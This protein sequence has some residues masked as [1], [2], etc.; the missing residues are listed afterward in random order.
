MTT[1]TARL[2][3]PAFKTSRLLD[4]VG[5][6]ELTAQI[7]HDAT[8][9]PLVVLKEGFDNALDACE[10]AGIAPVIL[11]E[12]STRAGEAMISVT[13]NGPGL[14]PET[15]DDI[16]DFSTR[17]SSREAYCS[18]TRGAQGNALKT[19]VAMPYALGDE[20]AE[21][22]IESRNTWHR[23]TFTADAVHQIPRIS[24][25]TEPYDVKNGTSLT[26][27]WPDSACSYLELEKGAFLQMC[28]GYAVLNPHLDLTARWDGE[29]YVDLRPSDE[30]W[31]K[32][33]ACNPTSPHWYTPQRLAR[34]AA[35]HVAR[36]QDNRRIRSVR[37]F[38]AEFRGLSSS[39]KQKTVAE[40]SGLGR[41]PLAALFNDGKANEASIAALLKAMQLHSRAVK[42][43]DLGVI[44]SDH[45]MEFCT[46]VGCLKETFRYRMITGETNEGVPFVVESGFAAAPESDQLR[47]LIFG[48]N[49]ASTLGNPFRSLHGTFYDGLETRLADQRC[50]QNEP[51]VVIL[52]LACA[53]VEYRDRGKSSVVLGAAIGAAV[54][55]AIYT[56]TGTWAKQRKAEE[57]DHTRRLRRLDRLVDKPVRVTLK[58]AARQVMRRA[59]EK[60]SYDGHEYLPTKARQVMYAARPEILALT[61][62]EALDDAYFTQTLLPDYIEAN[63]D[64]C[65]LWD[66]VWD[67]RGSFVEPHTALEVP[68]GTL[69]VRSYL[70][71]RAVSV[72]IAISTSWHYPTIGPEHR[73]DTVL[74]IEKEGFTP[75]IKAA[76]LA[77]RFDLAIKS[78]KGMSVTAAR[79]LLDRLCER[80]VKR[81]FVMHDFDI[82]GFSIFGTLGTSSRRYRFRNEV[83]LIDL[84]LR[85]THVE[86]MDLQSE[87]VVVAGDWDKRAA[88]LRQH[89]ATEDEIDYLRHRRVELNAMTSPQ[90]VEFIEAQLTQHGV[91]KLIPDDDVIEKHARHVIE[92]ELARDSFEKIRADFVEKA[93]IAKLPAD[94]RTRLETYLE[95]NPQ[96]SWDAALA[97]VIVGWH[98]D[99]RAP[100]K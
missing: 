32:W 33:S 35:A 47:R 51:V 95:R 85:L 82:W 11:V 50:S 68:L 98:L 71:R 75:L 3:R 56:V 63:R 72:P 40:E 1:A 10:E 28:A 100:T 65:K 16:L 38:I 91:S 94:L 9:W 2:E 97:T 12:V 77:E 7:G 60:S 74:L 73:F 39:A 31:V 67:A 34:Y 81:V 43:R 36:D 8:M 62:K 46:T 13:D 88:T 19:I 78:T 80:G 4:F 69:E 52:H 55:S 23:I 84:G 37:E 26:V 49:F 64:E 93:R 21:V 48:V 42:P 96:S 20:C 76:R 61:G 18:P 53:R 29:I 99:D 14:A 41:R 92:Q 25:E 30:A 54:E 89:G 87:P 27:F 58:E 22:Q 90:L 15:V 24:H 59:Y 5:R 86:A 57:R 6:R 79:Q 17:T 66:I 44:G 45:L 70:G 83:P